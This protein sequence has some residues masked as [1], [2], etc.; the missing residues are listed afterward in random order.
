MIV[1]LTVDGILDF[2]V[3]FQS[4]EHGNKGNP[5]GPCTFFQVLIADANFSPKNELF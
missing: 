1:D 3:E 4:L 5:L 2:F